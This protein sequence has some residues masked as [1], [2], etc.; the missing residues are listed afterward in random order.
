MIES[1]PFSIDDAVHR[2]KIYQKDWIVPPAVRLFHLTR[3]YLPLGKVNAI[4]GSP[5]A[6][7]AGSEYSAG[8]DME[9]KHARSK[10]LGL[11]RELYLQSSLRV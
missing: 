8:T 4:G 1:P 5:V 9:S 11:K 6:L 2:V 7:G 10:V 3:G